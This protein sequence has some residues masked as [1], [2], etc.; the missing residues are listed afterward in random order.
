MLQITRK[1]TTPDQLPEMR[2][3]VEKHRTLDA[4]M[5]AM[6]FL[7]DPFQKATDRNNARPCWQR[8]GQV[9][10]WFAMGKEILLPTAP[11]DDDEPQDD[12]PRDERD[13]ANDLA[14]NSYYR[15]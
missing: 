1:V 8:R 14:S 4:W 6:L 12:E 5:S 2:A 9:S 3:N 15:C 13:P 11:E 10:E 7:A